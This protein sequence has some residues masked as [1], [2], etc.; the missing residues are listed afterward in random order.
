MNKKTR[1]L[2]LGVC[3]FLGGTLVF[4]LIR[5]VPMTAKGFLIYGALVVVLIVLAIILPGGERTGDVK[6]WH[7]SDEEKKD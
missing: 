5:W 4:V 3:S 2:L 7:Q 6:R 1:K